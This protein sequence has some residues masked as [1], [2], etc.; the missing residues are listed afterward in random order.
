MTVSE[1]VAY[2]KGLAEGMGIDEN[3]KE[4]KILKTVIDILE[5]VAL[6]IED[7]NDGLDIVSED[8]SDVEEL[9]F[10]ED[11][12]DGCCSD[13]CCCGDE[14][15]DYEF[16]VECPSCGETIVLCESDLDLGEI[17]C[18]SCGEK[19]EFEFDEDEDEDEEEED[20]PEE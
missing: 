4:G 19:L 17:T 15:E 8:L 10:D 5:D 18:P 9:L 3:A 2:L 13:D 14:D 11:E 20:E 1:K 6:E 7:L 12:D 16:E